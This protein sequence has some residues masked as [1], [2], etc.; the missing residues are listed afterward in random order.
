MRL[1]P[2][3]I[4]NRI[5]RHVFRGYHIGDVE[6][7]RG[8]VSSALESLLQERAALLSEAE[9]LTRKVEYYNLTESTLQNALLLAEKTAED[10]RHAANK[11][12]ELILQQARQEARD[13]LDGA[14]SQRRQVQVEIESLKRERERFTLELEALLQAHMEMLRDRRKDCPAEETSAA[15]KL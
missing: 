10:R 4:E 13:I 8:E 7:F 1:T 15:V 12:A 2:V 9:T 6:A 14:A 5:F 3:D 11:E